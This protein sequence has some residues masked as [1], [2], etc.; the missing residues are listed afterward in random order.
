MHSTFVRTRST[1]VVSALLIAALLG[2]GPI[3]QLDDYHAFADARVVA[4]LAHGADVVSNIG[5]L[6]VG[7][8][9]LLLPGRREPAFAVLCAALVATACGSSWYHLAPDDVRLV[10][11]RL[12]IAIACT[13]VLACAS[14][15][16]L[17]PLVAFGIASVPWWSWSGDLR[18]YLLLQILPL[19]LVPLLQWQRADPPRERL[20]FGAA[21][22]L[23]ALAKVCELAD[24]A[25][26]GALQVVSGHTLKHV[27]ATLAALALVRLWGAASALKG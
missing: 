18:P 4:G 27:L 3:A 10:W 16:H 12:P 7:L 6:I 13:A 11:D 19:V 24:H 8:Y 17:I 25:V 22:A 15:R 21:V 2:T 5:F 14:G 9:G 1:W 20:L 23:Y 26:Y